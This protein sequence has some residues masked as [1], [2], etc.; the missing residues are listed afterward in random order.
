MDITDLSVVDNKDENRWEAHWED[1]LATLTYDLLDQ[2]ITLIRTWVPEPIEG[3]GVGSKIV[4]TA[5]DQARQNNFM[6]VPRCPFV[7]AYIKRHPQ[8]LDLVAHW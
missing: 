6:V 8:Y 7:A 4:K 5:L 2:E 3:Q 1:Q